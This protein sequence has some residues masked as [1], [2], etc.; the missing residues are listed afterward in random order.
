MIKSLMNRGNVSHLIKY[1]LQSDHTLELLR[2][3]PNTSN[4][5]QVAKNTLYKKEY[6]KP[7]SEDPN[8][9]YNSNTKPKKYFNNF[10]RSGHLTKDCLAKKKSVNVIVLQEAISSSQG[11]DM[12][13]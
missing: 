7:S 10:C 12:A 1:M 8:K 4:R 3:Q 6:E 5:P 13:E 2:N 9:S 11:K